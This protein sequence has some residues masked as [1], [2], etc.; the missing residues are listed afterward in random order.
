VKTLTQHA[1]P[2]A[3][4]PATPRRSVANTS[5]RGSHRPLGELHPERADRNRRMRLLVRIDSDRHYSDNRVLE[6]VAGLRAFPCSGFARTP[7]IGS[8]SARHEHAFALFA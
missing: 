1:R 8:Q 2:L 7:C 6:G 4:E 3:V 5:L